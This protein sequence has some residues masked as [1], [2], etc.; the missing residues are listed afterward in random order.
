MFTYNLF[1]A[2]ITQVQAQ[3]FKKNKRHQTKHQ[4]NNSV[5]G[6]NITQVT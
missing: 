1:F 6:V 4:R 2:N 3:A 5:I